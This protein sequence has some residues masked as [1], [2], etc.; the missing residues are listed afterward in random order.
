M[1]NQVA[2]LVFDIESVADPEL[3]ANVKYAGEQ[4][5][6]A[7]AVRRFRDERMAEYGSDFIPYTYQIPV[8]VAIAKVGR[9]FRLIDLVV[10]DEPEYRPH[11]ITDYFWRGW[12]AYNRPAFVTFN[13]RGFDLPLMELSA[14]RYGLSVPAWFA[15]KAKSYEQPRNRFNS[16]AHIDLCEVMTNF[17]ATRFNGGLNLAA[18][19]LGKPGK[20]DVEGDM[21]QDLYEAGHLAEINDYCRCDVLDTYFIFLRTRV[22]VGELSLDQEQQLVQEAKQWLTERSDMPAFANY[23]EHWGEWRNPWIEENAAEPAPVSDEVEETVPD[24]ASLIPKDETPEIAE[25]PTPDGEAI[26]PDLG[27]PPEGDGTNEM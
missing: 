14:F 20:M 10:L 22:L 7:E 1:P 3:V 21:V 2:Y 6:G 25:E 16:S 9:D 12:D 8:S 17:G 13:G 18:T 26:K 11:V 4:L 24:Q 27:L 23:L 15:T 5:E 19:L